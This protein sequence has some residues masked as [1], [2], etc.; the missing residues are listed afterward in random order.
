MTHRICWRCKIPHYE[1]CESCFGFGVYKIADRPGV[2]YPVTAGEAHDETLK[3]PV[4]LCPECGSGIHG[5]RDSR[6]VLATIGGIIF[7]PLAR[8]TPREK[9]I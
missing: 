3:S 4:I 7:G 9:G 6:P 2:A 5:L 1:N 8:L